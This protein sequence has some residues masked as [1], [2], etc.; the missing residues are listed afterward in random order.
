MIVPVLNKDIHVYFPSF[1]MHRKI[2]DAAALNQGLAAYS[3]TLRAQVAGVQKSNYGGWQSDPTLFS[4][5]EPCVQQLK[6][7]VVQAV[8]DLTAA[9]FA[10]PPAAFAFEDRLAAW[11]NINE[12]GDYNALHNHFAATWSGTYY[13]EAG[14]TAA[15]RPSSGVLELMDP[16]GLTIDANAPALSHLTR[17]AFNPEP[18]LLLVFPGYLS[19]L[20]HP[21][22]GKTP[23][24]SI[25]FNA[26]VRRT[27]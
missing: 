2:E 21:Y 17:V 18:G 16:R 14:E 26:L 24:I 9:T 12:T 7:A 19:H 5:S 22:A 4:A 1:V 27:A 3:R 6:A 20:V 13:V 15:E 25:A 8:R 10:L 23:R 11:V